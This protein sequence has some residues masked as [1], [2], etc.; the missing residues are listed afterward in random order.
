MLFRYKWALTSNH[1]GIDA[2]AKIGITTDRAD[3]RI[4]QLDS[5][6]QPFDVA[7]EGACSF[8]QSTI[9]GAA[10]EKA[11]RSLQAPF[12]T[13]GEWFESPAVLGYACQATVFQ[14]QLA[15]LDY[16]GFRR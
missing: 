5:T 10:A 6:Q 1:W 12:R 15:G 7:L 11:A 14:S 2:V 8:D 13:K 3:H 16:G 9:S 4:W